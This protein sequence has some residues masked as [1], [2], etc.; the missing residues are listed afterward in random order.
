M[1]FIFV[2][3]YSVDWCCS[4]I[5]YRAVKQIDNASMW[6]RE[7]FLNLS[8]ENGN[9]FCSVSHARMWLRKKKNSLTLDLSFYGLR[10]RLG[11]SSFSILKTT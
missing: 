9:P 3:R 8:V 1:Y 2:E 6:Y 10:T 4:Q 5:D 7:L 11:V